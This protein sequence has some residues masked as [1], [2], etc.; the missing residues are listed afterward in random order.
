MENYQIRIAKISHHA[1]LIAEHDYV[2]LIDNNLLTSRKRIM[3]K[4][5]TIALLGCATLTYAQHKETRKIGQFNGISVSQGIRAEFVQSNRN[6]VVVDVSKADLLAKIETKVSN[7]TLVIRVKPNSKIY[8]AKN[9]SV[10]VYSNARLQQVSAS[11]AGKLTSTAAIH[12]E[13]FKAD[14]SSSGSI[15]LGKIESRTATIHASSAGKVQGQLRVK[16][17]QIDASSSGSVDLQGSATNAK[18]NASSS[19][20]A[21]LD[22]LSVSNVNVGASSGAS[23][24]I[25]VKNSIVANAS[26]GG[27][28]KYSGNPSKTDFNRSSG[29]SVSSK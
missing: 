27:D 16:E 3:K 13:N 21:L 26:S 8:N 29:G 10:T 11:S 2:L 5:L 18:I 4:L 9:L 22:D 20:S 1:I 12:T 6:E 24:H 17:L 23:V 14:A 15:A 25:D 19:G 28:I 7:N